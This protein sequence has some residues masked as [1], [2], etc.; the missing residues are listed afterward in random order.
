MDVE[1]V[2]R[3]VSVGVKERVRP[4]GK[5][6]ITQTVLTHTHTHTSNTEVDEIIEES[7][8]EEWVFGT[9]ETELVSEEEGESKEY[10][11]HD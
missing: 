5:D 3:H 6:A 1:L 2:V 9:D 4:V 7:L 10:C 8:P 11:H